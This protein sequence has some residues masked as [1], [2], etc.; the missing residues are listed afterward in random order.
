MKLDDGPTTK[1]TPNEAKRQNLFSTYYGLRCRAGVVVQLPREGPR[2]K[3]GVASTMRISWR[4]SHE[5]EKRA[6]WDVFGD[7]KMMHPSIAKAA[8][9]FYSVRADPL[10]SSYM[11]M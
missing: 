5:S 4:Q 6:S 11:Y 8:K 10:D 2:K 9:A 3:D 7:V 1:E